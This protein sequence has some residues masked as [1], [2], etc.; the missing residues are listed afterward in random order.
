MVLRRFDFCSH[1]L[2]LKQ[3]IQL[4]SQPLSGITFLS[5]SS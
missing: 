3:F 1:K 5:Y 2:P 4:E